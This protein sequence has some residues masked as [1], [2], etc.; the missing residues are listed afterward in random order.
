MNVS[1]HKSP[2]FAREQSESEFQSSFAF[3]IAEAED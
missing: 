1:M 2:A 3:N